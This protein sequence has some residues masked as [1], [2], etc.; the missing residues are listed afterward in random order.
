MKAPPFSLQ[1]KGILSQSWQAHCVLDQFASSTTWHF[2][3]VEYLP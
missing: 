2:G 1:E 3:G